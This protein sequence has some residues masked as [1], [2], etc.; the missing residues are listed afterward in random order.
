MLP[1][2]VLQKIQEELIDW[3][4]LQQSVLE[5]GHRTTAFTDFVLSVEAKLRQIL[6]IPT[7]YEVIFLPG[8][9][10]LQFAAIPLNLLGKNSNAA[11]VDTGIWSRRAIMEAQ[12]YGKVQVV[13][14]AEP[15]DNFVP[16]QTT[17][18]DFK[19]AAYLHYTANETIS[20]V[21]F[22]FIPDTGSV[23]LV[24]DMTS[25]LLM[26][27]LDVNRFGLIYAA[28]QKNIGIGGLSLVIIRNDLLSQ[29]MPSVPSVLDYAKQVEAHSRYNTPPTFAIYVTNLILDWINEQ[30]GLATLEKI[31][32]R[33]A[34]K[35]Y[36][37]IDDS[38]GFY[39]NGIEPI[40]R[41]LANVVFTL[42]D[43]KLEQLFAEE[44]AQ[45][46][47]LNLRGHRV[48]GGIRASIYNAM[49]EEGVDK[50][51]A[52]MHQFQLKNSDR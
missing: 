12:R 27:T 28:T 52:F 50:L 7:N 46:G 40:C 34:D 23:P 48:V 38:D 51:V 18:A 24:V 1:R 35:L 9:A 10:N 29:A 11:Y 49:P 36:Q 37:C 19:N 22:P 14:S 21:E 4:N 41:S 43:E 13:A 30:G 3:Q 20:G 31:N 15:E 33:K 16:A 39:H 6:N 17:W 32:R 26:N 45:Q 47:L 42:P 5:I 25:N 8:G 44:A 2:P